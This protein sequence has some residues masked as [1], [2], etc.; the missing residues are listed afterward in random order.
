[1]VEISESLRSVHSVTLEE[2]N[3][4]FVLEVPTDQITHDTLSAGETYRVAILD[5]VTTPVETEST[6]KQDQP[7][8]PPVTQG[9]IRRVTIETVGDQGDGIAKVDRGFVVI[10]PE[11]E[12]GDEP[13]V[14]IS[15]VRQNVA[16]A[17]PVDR[18]TL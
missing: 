12:P 5:T 7:V 17:N 6:Q 16:F 8:T 15:Q 13:L 9:E 10:V 2:R 18:H 1:M 3:G 14:E 11:A 4:E